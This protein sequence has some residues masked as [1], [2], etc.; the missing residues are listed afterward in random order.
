MQKWLFYVKTHRFLLL[1]IVTG[2]LFLPLFALFLY[3]TYQTLTLNYLPVFS[4]EYGYYLDAKSFWLYNRIDAAST[5]NE[6]FSLIGH[7]GFH[8]FMYSILYGTAFKLFSLVGITPSIALCNIFLIFLLFVFLLLLKIKLE[9]KFLIGIVVLSNFIF[10]IY[11][12]S[13]MTEIFHYIFAV[14]VAYTLHLLY[15]TRST[16]YLLVLLALLV[17]LIPFRESWVFILFALFPLSRSIREFVGYTVLLVLGLAFV[18]FYQKYFQAAFPVDYF[19]QIKSQLNNQSLL[20]ILD[21]LYEHFIE[22]IDKY[23]ISETYN[24]YRFVFY[25]K[26]LF[27]I[28]LVYSFVDAFLSKNREILS[29]ALVSALFFSALLVLYDPFGWREVRTLAAPF[30]LMMVILILNRRYISVS[31]IILFQ[32]LNL[33][34]VIDAKE[35][36]DRNRS[37][38]NRLIVESADKLK[39]FSDFGTYIEDIKK[40]R[41]TVLIDQGLIPFDNS[42]LFY[43]LPL[44]VADKSVTYSFIYRQFDISESKCDIFISNRKL[45]NDRLELLG[46]NKYYYFYRRVP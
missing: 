2:I 22:N 11:L 32:L 30:V 7:S 3:F 18:L 13:S 38:M 36:V 1:K 16:R 35:S 39:A 14:P 6:S 46:S 10:I 8:G 31:L 37:D 45:N 5:L 4:D 17:F 41:V 43:Q 23:F 15:Q 21:P 29:A 24:R 33:G 42:P 12:S 25:Y 28:V 9:Q 19:H 20:H 27:V 44:E 26:Y 34:D 40:K